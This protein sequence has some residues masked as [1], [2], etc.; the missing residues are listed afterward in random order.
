[1]IDTRTA[2]YIM[3]TICAVTGTDA[4][5]WGILVKSFAVEDA[6]FRLDGGQGSDQIVLGH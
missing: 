5:N 4:R 6:V 1:M 3:G 2:R